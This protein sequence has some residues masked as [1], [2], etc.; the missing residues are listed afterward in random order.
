MFAFRNSFTIKSSGINSI[1]FKIEY[2]GTAVINE[3][4]YQL[5]IFAFDAVAIGDRVNVTL[6]GADDVTYS[7]VDSSSS[8]LV[9]QAVKNAAVQTLKLS[10]NRVETVSINSINLFV[11]FV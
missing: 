5:G 8:K 1:Q 2:V 3:Q 7:V 11:N 10:G 6:K 4:K 9:L